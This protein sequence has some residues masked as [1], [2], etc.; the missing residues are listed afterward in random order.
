[1]SKKIYFLVTVIVL[2]LCSCKDEHKDLK[3][4]LYA[5]IETSKGTIIAELNYVKA[6]IMVSNFVTLA[7]GKNQ[8]VTEEFRGKPF[9]DG[10]TFHCRWNSWSWSN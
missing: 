3:D 5:E 10:L 9:F 8:F 1:M 2:S 6:P 4:G 7:E